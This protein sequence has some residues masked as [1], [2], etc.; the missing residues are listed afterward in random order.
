[1]EKE[2]LLEGFKLFSAEER[3]VLLDALAQGQRELVTALVLARR[4]PGQRPGDGRR[5]A[6]FGGGQTAQGNRRT[7]S[8]VRPGPRH[9]S[10]PVCMSGPGAGVPA[11]DR[12][13]RM[14]YTGA[15]FRCGQGGVAWR[16]AVT[17]FAEA[18]TAT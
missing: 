16:I 9:E 13:E 5:P 15:T 4:T 1:M 6:Y 14:Y 12:I 3:E 11:L 7:A 8:Q 17:A 18:D 2:V 10:V